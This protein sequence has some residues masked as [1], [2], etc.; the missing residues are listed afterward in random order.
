ME[1]NV[2][3]SIKNTNFSAIDG[4]KQRIKSTETGEKKKKV[5]K[6]QE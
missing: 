2:L 6:P 4:I 5:Q 3:H 1:V